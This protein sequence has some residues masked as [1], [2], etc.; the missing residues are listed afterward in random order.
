[1]FQDSLWFHLETPVIHS[2][3]RFPNP[4]YQAGESGLIL[5]YSIH[6]TASSVVSPDT[7][8]CLL[9]I[10]HKLI[11]FEFSCWSHK[12]VHFFWHFLQACDFWPKSSHHLVF[13]IEWIS[14]HMFNCQQYTFNCSAVANTLNKEFYFF[15]LKLKIVLMKQAWKMRYLLTDWSGWLTYED[16]IDNW[17]FG[18][19]AAHWLNDLKRLQIWQ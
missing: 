11:K 17:D 9:T 10:N 12:T 13:L 4:L 6:E 1:M 18:E 7:S 15:T 5:M 3:L 8:C 14:L 19:I 2:L 16:C